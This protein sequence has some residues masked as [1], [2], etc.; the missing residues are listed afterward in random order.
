MKMRTPGAAPSTAAAVGGGATRKRSKLNIDDLCAPMYVVRAGTV[1]DTIHEVLF[2]AEIDDDKIILHAEAYVPAVGSMDLHQ[3]FTIPP[4]LSTRDAVEKILA[5]KATNDRATAVLKE[6]LKLA[7]GF[8]DY[9]LVSAKGKKLAAAKKARAAASATSGGSMAED[10]VEDIPATEAEAPRESKRVTFD[11]LIGDGDDTPAGAEHHH[12]NSP[13][14]IA[15]AI[16]SM[17]GVEPLTSEQM[18]ELRAADPDAIMHQA[19]E[20]LQQS[21]ENMGAKMPDDVRQ[22]IEDVLR[23]QVTGIR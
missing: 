11:D 4:K 21:Y 16:R 12:S 13:E 9:D 20:E 15:N 18:V 14:G 2:R 23:T 1:G 17:E 3:T 5:K 7:E 8:D 6:F 22:R 19:A 10:E